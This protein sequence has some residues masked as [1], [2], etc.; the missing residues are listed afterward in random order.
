[1]QTLPELTLP[2]SFVDTANVVLPC[3]FWI[4]QCV[5]NLRIVEV[6]EGRH[7]EALFSECTQGEILCVEGIYINEQAGG[8]RM[9]GFW[10]V[11]LPQMILN[12]SPQQ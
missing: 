3:F 6:V 8:E 1:M 9:N 5:S 7:A 11:G 2:V 10:V 4:Q 12:K